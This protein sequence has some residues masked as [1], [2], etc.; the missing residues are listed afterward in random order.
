VSPASR[1]QQA[2]ITVKPNVVV[3][4]G[5]SS[6]GKVRQA[7]DVAIGQAKPGRSHFN[8]PTRS[9]TT[10]PSIRS[11]ITHLLRHR[12]SR[13]RDHVILFARCLPGALKAVNLNFNVLP[14][15][16]TNVR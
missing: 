9:K 8:P 15:A 13:R 6:K 4:L 11:R 1:R 3:V 10:H 12:R 5:N 14:A 16:F 2:R 7:Y